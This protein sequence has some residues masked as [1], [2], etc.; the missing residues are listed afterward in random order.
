MYTRPG[1]SKFTS[2]TNPPYVRRH[3]AYRSDYYYLEAVLDY[4]LHDT[5]YPWC[6]LANY[7]RL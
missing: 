2:V 6:F 1:L 5:K 4:V 7:I 3:T